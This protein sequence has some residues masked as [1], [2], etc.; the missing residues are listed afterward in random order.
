VPGKTKHRA[1]IIAARCASAKVILST[2]LA[3][4]LHHFHEP[5]Y[6]DK[7]RPCDTHKPLGENSDLP[8][9]EKRA[10]RHDEHGYYRMMH[11]CTLSA[12]HLVVFHHK[13]KNKSTATF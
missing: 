3:F 7:H 8:Q 13:K 11:T 1:A 10:E 2:A 4:A 12:I 6:D 5:C 9:K